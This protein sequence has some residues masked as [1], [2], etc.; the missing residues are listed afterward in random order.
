MLVLLLP[1]SGCSGLPDDQVK[2]ADQLVQALDAAGN[3]MAGRLAEYDRFV[4]ENPE[5]EAFF[6]PYAE[7]ENWRQKFGNARQELDH[8][9]DVYANQIQ[10]M[11]KRNKPDESTQFVALLNAVDHGIA[12]TDAA[13]GYPSKR[14]AFLREA[15]E[16]VV[17]WMTDARQSADGVQG[18]VSGLD[19][20]RTRA[21]ADYPLKAD[22]IASRFAPI[23]RWRDECVTAFT[24]AEAEF[25]KRESGTIDY[26]LFGDNA[27]QAS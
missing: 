6:R 14:M 21:T 10:P 16:N 22:D 1:L 4:S 18:I 12:D 19:G 23:A 27:Q 24:I 8:A 5:Y 11:R 13:R 15:K 17:E 9:R 7:R 2:R 26:A 25:A 20:Y 3:R